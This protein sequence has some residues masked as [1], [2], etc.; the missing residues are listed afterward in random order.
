MFSKHRLQFKIEKINDDFEMLS[1]VDQKLNLVHCIKDDSYRLKDLVEFCGKKETD[2][3]EAMSYFHM[4]QAHFEEGDSHR[5]MELKE[6]ENE[7]IKGYYVSKIM[8]RGFAHYLDFMKSFYIDYLI[9]TREEKELVFAKFQIHAMKEKID[10][11]KSQIEN[12]KSVIETM[13]DKTV[14]ENIKQKHF[15]MLAYEDKPK[16][17]KNI[18]PGW[19]R[20]NK[21]S[22]EMNKHDERYD[23]KQI[24][25]KI[26]NITCNILLHNSE[27]I[28]YLIEKFKPSEFSCEDRRILIKK[29]LLPELRIHL[30]NFFKENYNK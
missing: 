20:L 22:A 13:K 15:Y 24:F 17:L 16:N 5:L 8:I 26:E 12:L 2:K 6:S 18:P 4:V 7:N 3:T 28:P 30:L 10:D 23:D 9:D 29:D 21:Y 25:F 1:L 14:P 27:I 11:L 19:V